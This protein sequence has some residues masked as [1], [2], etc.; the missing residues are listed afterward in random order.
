MNLQELPLI[1]RRAALAVLGSAALALAACGG[2]STA[3][4]DTPAAGTKLSLALV[5]TTD[6]HT[7]V[8]S[9]DYYTT[10]DTNTLGLDRAAT[11]IEAIRKDHPNTLLFDNGDTIQGTALADYQASVE[12]VSCDQTLAIFKAM[13]YL[14]YD[15]MSVGNHEFNYGLDF[16]SQVTHNANWNPQYANC[17]GP[18]F[19]LVTANVYKTADKQGLYAPYTLLDRQF[20][21]S[22]GKAYSLK[23][24]VIGFTPPPIMQWDKRWLEGNVYTEG[25]KEMAAKYVPEMR[26][27][28]ADVV[29][30][31]VHGGISTAPYSPTMENAAYYVADVPGIDAMFMGHS[32]SYFPDGKNYANLPEVDNVKGTIKGVPAIMGGFWGNSVGLMKMELSWDG[33]QWK[34]ASATSSLQ[35]INSKDASGTAVVIPADPAIKALIQAEHDATVNYVSTPIGT[36]EYR[37]ASQ[38]TQVGDVGVVQLIN[39]A[40]IAAYKSY[41]DANLPQYAGLPVLS[42]A[43]PFKMNFRATGYTDI[44]AGGVAIKDMANLYVYP[45]TLQAV[46]ITGADVKLWLEKSAQYFNTIDPAKT[47]DQQLIDSTFPSY[48]FDVIQ[49]SGLTYEIDVTKPVGQR[50]VNLRMNGAALDPAAEVIVVTNN[51]RASG[52]GKFIGK[53][54]PDSSYVIYESPDENREAII[55]FVKAQKTLTRAANASNRNWRF[56]KTATAGKVLFESGPNALQLAIDDGITHVT[57]DSTKPDGSASIYQLHLDQ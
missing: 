11:L 51:Y 42:A 4:A 46:K 10:Q 34:V 40:Q 16:L 38:F 55:S 39:D 45:N 31:L 22:D 26:S 28:G 47:A 30:A 24:G 29:V 17:K 5:E 36:S 53:T 27:K 12:R 8:L 54:F 32:H 57:L 7:N 41:A 2:D 52:L 19:P 56:V 43:A 9:Y 1:S 25:V 13:N 50:I 37:I 44:P 6:L 49:G 15:A 33:K 14:K 48:N 21:A 20:T 18:D 23:I 3:A 35:S